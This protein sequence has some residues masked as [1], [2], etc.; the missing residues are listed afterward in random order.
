MFIT[1]DTAA[2]SS[3]TSGA[4]IN[5]STSSDTFK[6]GAKSLKAT[7]T[8]GGGSVS[9]FVIAAPIEKHSRVGIELNYKKIDAATGT[10]YITCS[11]A[12]GYK[13]DSNGV[14][15]I[16]KLET[17]GTE[18]LSISGPTEWVNVTRKEPFGKSP[19]WATHIAI[20]V[21]MDGLAAGSVYFDD[22]VITCG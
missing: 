21:N 14:P 8:F 17:I 7:K 18:T 15:L 6:T 4:N 5:I 3:R 2:I 20:L 16:S 12:A 19:A 22:V 9:S 13:V 1:S 11:Y 10:M